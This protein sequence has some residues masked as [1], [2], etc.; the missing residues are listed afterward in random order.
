MDFLKKFGE[1][2]LMSFFPALA[3]GLIGWFI[4]HRILEGTFPVRI[5][6]IL[7]FSSIFSIG[8]LLLRFISKRG[9]N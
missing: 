2:D 6:Q 8:W 7:L 1:K 4:A 5:E 3:G 9:R